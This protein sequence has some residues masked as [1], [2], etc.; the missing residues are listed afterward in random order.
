MMTTELAETKP[1]RRGRR[2][3]AEVVFVDLPKS[4]LVALEQAR[5]YDRPDA[6]G[7]DG[8]RIIV[9]LPASSAFLYNEPD[10]EAAISRRFTTLDKPQAQA[11]AS[12]MKELVKAHRRRNRAPNWATNY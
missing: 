12:Y 11:A 3:R 1:Q 6:A 8:E 7:D 10:A 2:Q 9:Q 4:V 5:F